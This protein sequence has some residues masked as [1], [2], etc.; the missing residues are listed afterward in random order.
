MSYIKY[1][2]ITKIE[3]IT[4][5]NRTKDYIKNNFNLDLYDKIKTNYY[6]KSNILNENIA[7]FRKEIL[8]FTNGKGDSINS[9]EAYYLDI[10]GDELLKNK[11]HLTLDNE[12]Y[13]F[14]NYDYTFETDK[15]FVVDEHMKICLY[16]IAIFWDINRVEFEN[17]IVLSSLVG[18]L[19]KCSSTNV[20]KDASFLTVV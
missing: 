17:S 6:L 8:R 13:F 16:S 14:S 5:N 2:I 3:T 19:I 18:N 12:K 15:V 20:L 4:N 9:Y 11:I 1:G 7:D 10:T